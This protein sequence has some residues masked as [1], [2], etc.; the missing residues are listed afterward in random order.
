MFV[1]R[2]KLLFYSFRLKNPSKLAI[3]TDGGFAGESKFDIVKVN[4]LV[5][6][7]ENGPI[8]IPLPDTELP[9]YVSNIAQAIIDHGGMKSKM[10]VDSWDASNEVAVSKYAESLIQL[11]G[12]GKISQ[13]PTSWR[14]EMSGDCQDLVVSNVLDVFS[15]YRRKKVWTRI[16]GI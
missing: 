6:V 1:S 15:I 3:G 10:Q 12:K 11:E 4:Q 5:V 14:C 13:D 2:F 16:K 9:E 8:F 7:T